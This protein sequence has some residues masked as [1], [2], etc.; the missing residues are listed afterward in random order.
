MNHIASAVSSW[1]ADGAILAL[2]GIVGFALALA[3]GA[4]TGQLLCVLAL[5]QER[6]RHRVRI[7][8]AHAARKA[9]L[10]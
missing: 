5:K 4:V 7:A 6:R 9:R 3:L 2:V 10:P 8:R 1:F